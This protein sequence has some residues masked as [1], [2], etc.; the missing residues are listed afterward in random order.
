MH[1]HDRML[2]LEAISSLE[3]APYDDEPFQ[4]W[5]VLEA[6]RIFKEHQGFP[7]VLAAFCPLDLG[8]NDPLDEP[9]PTPAIDLPFDMYVW[10]EVRMS[11][12]AH[13][14]I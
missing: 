14:F 10:M 2:C 9:G 8:V 4:V 12:L 3:P 5:C 13:D 7:D 1:P 11:K 6:I